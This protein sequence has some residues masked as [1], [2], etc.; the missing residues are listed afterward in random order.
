MTTVRRAVGQYGERVA[1]RHLIGQGLTVLARNWRCRAGEVDLILLDGDDLVICEGKTRR[2][3]AFGSPAEAIRPD[4]V[5]RLRRL[6]GLWLAQS[7]AHPRE[8]R[9]DVVE[10]RPQRRGATRVEHIRAAF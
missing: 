9:F 8:I 1:E 6:A 3:G 2:G 5:A 7:G 10:V 4:K